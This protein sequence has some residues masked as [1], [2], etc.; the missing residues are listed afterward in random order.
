MADRVKL[1]VGQFC[2][3]SVRDYL[4]VSRLKPGDKIPPVEEISR[5]LDMNIVIVRDS[6]NKLESEGILA[7]REGELCCGMYF[8]KDRDEGKAVPDFYMLKNVTAKD[9]A[10]V[11]QLIEPPAA[12]I[13]ASSITFQELKELE[14]NIEYCE[15]I[16]KKAG[17]KISEEDFIKIEE[18]TI[19]FH[20][21]LSK[22]THNPVLIL[23]LDYSYDFLVIYKN[24]SVMTPDLN[25]CKVQVEGH[26]DIVNLLRNRDAKK[27]EKE[28]R[29][30][31]RLFESYILKKEK[32]E[33]SSNNKE[34]VKKLF[35]HI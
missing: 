28:V 35:K 30:H 5:Q 19:E 26:R 27:V 11:R 15:R 32:K 16:L 13:A 6:I 25:F 33:F 1:K 3:E 12:A 17:N 34:V 31:I 23:T 9:L 4:L 7:K 20:R 29:R 14:T 10:Q 22:A 8:S 2:E 24:S 18:N 21:L